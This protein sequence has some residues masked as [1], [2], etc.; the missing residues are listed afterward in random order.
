MKHQPKHCARGD[1]M[2][3]IKSRDT[4][5][6]RLVRSLLHRQGFRFALH[7]PS[8]PGTP[9]IVLPKH[10]AVVL[11]HGCFWHRHPRCRFAFAPKTNQSYW[12][13]KFRRNV[14]RDRENR[15]SLVR[16]GWKVIVVWTCELRRPEMVARR[17]RQRIA[18]SKD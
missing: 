4:K 3:R 7:C 6:E 15:L 14:E 16:E 17:L 10:R 1:I 12:R 18:R 9:D 5:P 8:L 11:V 13:P 2:C